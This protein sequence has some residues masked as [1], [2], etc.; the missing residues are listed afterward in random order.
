[1]NSFFDRLQYDCEGID[2]IGIAGLAS[3]ATQ[4]D[5]NPAARWLKY[6]RF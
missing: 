5:L 4:I 3:N 1:M 6:P 2:F